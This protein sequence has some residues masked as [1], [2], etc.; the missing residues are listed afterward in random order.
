MNTK[1]K[2]ENS[3]KL[4][5]KKE[6]LYVNSSDNVIGVIFYDINGFYFPEYDWGDFVVA[7]LSWLT[8]VISDLQSLQD[9][10]AE[11]FFM[12]G[13][14]KIELQVN[15]NHQCKINFIEGNRLAGDE[16]IIHKSI[17]V[18]L[19]EV[20]DEV[21]KSCEMIIQMKESK[22]LDFELDYEELLEAYHSLVGQQS[23]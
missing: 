3:F 6:T 13:C 19:S 5:I 4:I 18:P 11:V 1:L 9:Q 23:H 10:Q 16:E 14:F 2:K 7:I 20:I 12:E 17:T 15:K 8:K 22:E 21:T